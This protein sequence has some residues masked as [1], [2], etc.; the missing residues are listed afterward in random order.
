MKKQ[1]AIALVLILAATGVAHLH[2]TSQT[3]HP[4]VKVSAPNGVTFT[5]V[6]AATNR[7]ACAAANKRFLDPMRANCSECEVE[8]ARCE[9]ELEGMELALSLDLPVPY[10]VVSVPG[11]RLAITADDAAPGFTSTC[12][13]IAGD[14]IKRGVGAECAKASPTATRGY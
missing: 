7:P 5:A 1:I 12:E 9:R 4:V 10:P 3:Y 13:L 11:A 2:A 6:L 14:V 8:A